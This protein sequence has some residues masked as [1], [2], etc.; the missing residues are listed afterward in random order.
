MFRLD[1]KSGTER[2]LDN[3]QEDRYLGT[4]TM[5]R[6]VAVYQMHCTGGKG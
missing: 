5:G 4:M 2:L 3:K 1:E 6:R